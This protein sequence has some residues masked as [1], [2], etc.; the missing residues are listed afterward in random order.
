MFLKN[1]NLGNEIKCTCEL[2]DGTGIDVNRSGIDGIAVIC[3]CN[4]RGYYTLK[5]NE[6]MQLVQ[7]E[8]TGVIY[9]VNNGIIDG[10]VTLFNELKKRDDVNYVMYST[11]EPIKYLLGMFGGVSEP[12]AI[13]YSEFLKGKLPLP[14]KGGNCPKNISEDYGKSEFVIGRCLYTPSLA[15]NKYYTLECW[16]EFYGE[17][18]TNEEKQKVL[19][20]L[21]RF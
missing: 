4:G 1:L 11:V 7:D 13:R 21:T 15:C 8:Q 20:K 14:L 16:E 19:K 12:W 2:C 10:F 6:G 5:L 17:A 18:K 3:R 9:K